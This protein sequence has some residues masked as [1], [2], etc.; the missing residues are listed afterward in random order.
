MPNLAK[1]IA[2]TISIGPFLDN[3]DGITPETGLAGS[4]T[5]YLSKDG[6]AMAARNSTDSIS[7]DSLGHYR[8]PLN[9]T[10]TNTFG[11]LRVIVHSAGA[12][13]LESEFDVIDEVVKDIY[14]GAGI[15]EVNLI[16]IAGDTYSPPLLADLVNNVGIDLSASTIS[17]DMV[18]ISGDATAANNA[19]AAFDGTGYAFPNSVIDADV[20]LID[21]STE[22]A[23]KWAAV[24]TAAIAGEAVTGTLTSTVM[25]TNLTYLSIDR[26]NGRYVF[27]LDG[28]NAGSAR[29]IS[30]FAQTN[31]TITLATAL[32]ALPANGDTFVII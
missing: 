19:E 29:E 3:T 5:V 22:A 4:M 15:W 26:L 20:Q 16:A 21:G 13:P 9:G 18:S 31:G 12:L 11:I 8:I 28:S 14:D 25:T 6:G 23:T 1:N 24:A 27:F 30:D 32:V 17:A 2:A 7:H 10:D